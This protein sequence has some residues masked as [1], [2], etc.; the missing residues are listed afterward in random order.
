MAE[1][2]HDHAAHRRA[3]P[4][5]TARAWMAVGVGTLLAAPFYLWALLDLF[6][7]TVSLTR[8]ESPSSTYTLQA[9]ALIHGHLWVRPGSLG[10]E[11]FVV[12]G[13]TYT[14]F[15]L[16]PSLL[17]VPFLLLSPSIPLTAFTAPSFGKLTAPKAAQSWLKTLILAAVIP[18]SGI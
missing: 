7:G 8:S 11:G 2:Q 6:S 9:Q 18:I 4:Q 17:R 15:G 10:I 14:Y 12:H 13:H 16:F 5:A 1:P 3:T